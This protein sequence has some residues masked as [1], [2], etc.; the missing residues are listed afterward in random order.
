MP[1]YKDLLQ[2][3]V[4]Q[5]M[6]TTVSRLETGGFYRRQL[7]VC[8]ENEIMFMMFIINLC[9]TTIIS[10]D[11]MRT[12]DRNGGNTSP[13]TCRMRFQRHKCWE[14]TAPFLW[15]Q[16]RPFD[17]DSESNT[18]GTPQSSVSQLFWLMTIKTKP[19]TCNPLFQVAY[20]N[21]L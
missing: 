21:V 20:V 14:T 11:F 13:D 3:L 8:K 17:T 2:H 10:S 15:L 18:Q 19:S 12:L 1:C 6:K 7:E 16:N 4:L 9:S 5:Y